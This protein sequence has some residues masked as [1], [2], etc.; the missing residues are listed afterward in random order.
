MT[1]PATL[2][3]RIALLRGHL[4]ALRAS[5]RQEHERSIAALGVIAI[6]RELRHVAEELARRESWAPSEPDT[7]TP[8]S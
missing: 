8:G 6:E 7:G 5:S 4:D 1:L 2:R 3:A